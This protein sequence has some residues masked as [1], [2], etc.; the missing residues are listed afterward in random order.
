RLVAKSGV[1][2]EARAANVA[3]EA[4]EGLAEA[5]ALGIV[6][7]DVKPANLFLARTPRGG[8]IVKILDFG[9]SKATDERD[10][11]L[12]EGER[13]LGSPSFMSPEQIKSARDVDARTDVWSLGVVLYF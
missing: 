8:E 10:P 1:L 3:L 4:C 12:T 9:I 2:S 13:V 5:H 7:R 11:T 6:H